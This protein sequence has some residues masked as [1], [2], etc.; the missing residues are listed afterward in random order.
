[1]GW[2]SKIENPVVAAL[3]IRIWRL[4]ADLD[5]SDAREQEFRSMHACFTRALKPGARTIDTTPGVLSSPCD[6][7][8]GAC[9]TL[10]GINA[11]QAKGAPYP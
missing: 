4:F 2:F 9:G 5:L 7:I 10:E 3:S 6:A 11:L 8:V 1:M